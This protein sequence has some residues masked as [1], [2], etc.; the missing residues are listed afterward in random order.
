MKRKVI[1]DDF[2]CCHLASSLLSPVMS[3]SSNE[4]APEDPFS[5][6][7]ISVTEVDVL[8]LSSARLERSQD[9]MI[10][11]ITKLN[12]EK[13]EG[14]SFVNFSSLDLLVDE[15]GSSSTWKLYFNKSL[16]SVETPGCFD[17]PCWP[18]SF[19]LLYQ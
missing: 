8:F 15:C 11:F 18:G 5:I 7:K 16:L 19:G 12:F 1:L 4:S 17:I 13:T 9:L 2:N 3:V 6:Q 14:N 10:C